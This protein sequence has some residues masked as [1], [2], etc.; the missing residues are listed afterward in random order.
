MTIN[1]AWSILRGA[2]TSATYY[3]KTKTTDPLIFAFKPIIQQS[4][5]KVNATKYW[6]DLANAYNKVNLFNKQQLNPDLSDYVTRKALYGIFYEIALQ[7]IQ[8]RQNPAAR[9]TDL[10]KKVFAQK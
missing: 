10:L 2:D 3:L 7:E 9:T 6:S 5:E 8:I 4:L 1:D